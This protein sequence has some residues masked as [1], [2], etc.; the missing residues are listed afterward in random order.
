MHSIVLS[1]ATA[2]NHGDAWANH[3]RL[4]R[5]LFIER[6]KWDVPEADGMEYDT[7][8]TPAARYV[9]VIGDHGDVIAV[10]RLI[11]TTRPIMVRDIWPQLLGG[12]DPETDDYW[13]ATRFGVDEDLPLEIRE[14]AQNTLILGVQRFGLE[15]NVKSFIGVMP[16]AFFRR[17]GSTGVPYEILGPTVKLPQYRIVAAKIDVSHD[18]ISSLEQSL[19]IRSDAA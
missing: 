8:D 10:T 18:A 11:P 1:W 16:K 12:W 4:R 6:N 14:K 7:Y 17:I 3:H 15:H 5:K 19:S 9:L 2:H 13:E